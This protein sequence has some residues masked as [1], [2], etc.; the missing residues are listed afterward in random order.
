MSLSNESARS[1]RGSTADLATSGHDWRQGRFPNL[2]PNRIQEVLLVSS[3]YDSFILEEDGLLTEMVFTEYLDLGLTH[4]PN[5]TRVTNG[6]EALARLREE[7][8]DLVITMLRL[9]DMNVPKFGQAVRELRPGLPLVLLI[10]SEWELARVVHQQENLNVDGIY[11]WHGDTKLFIAIIKVIEDRL[12]AAHDAHT[13]DVGVII[14]VEDSVRFRSSLL[15]IVYSELVKQTRAV[16]TEGLNHMDKL[17]RM[18]ARPKVLVAETYEQGIEYYRRFRKQLFGVIADVSFPRAG[19]QNRRAGIDFIRQIKTNSPDIPALLQSSDLGNRELA[20]LVGAR[21]L[22]KRSATLLEDLRRFMLDHFGFGDF[23]FRLRDGREVAR[24]ANLQQMARVL[25]DVPTESVEY[26]AVRN[27]FSNWLR[28]RTEFALARRLRPRQVSEFEN[29]EDLRRYL[30]RGISEAIG[31]NRRGLV[32]DFSRQRF[33]PESGFARIG[34]GSMGGKARG[35]AFV[36][37]LLARSELEDEFPDIRVQVPPTVVI[38]TDIFDEFLDSNGIRHDV[39]CSN[40]DDWIRR[41]F[42]AGRLPDQVFEDLRVFIDLVRTP[43]AVRSSSLLEDSQYYPFAGV[44]TTFMLPNNASDDTVRLRQLRDAI[45]LVLASTFLTTARRYL[46]ATPHRIEEEKMAVILQPIIGAQRGD[47]FYPDFSG[48]ARSYNYYP[49]GQMKPEDGVATVALGLGKTVVDGGQALRF[50]PAHPQILPQLAENEVFIDQ[51]QRAFYAVDLGGP[52]CNPCA[53]HDGCLKCLDL[54]DAENHGTLHLL[55]SV[56]SPDDAA[57]Y[58]GIHRPGVRVV[59]FAH[60]LKSEA[61]PLA[62]LLRSLLHI[63]RTGMNSPVEIEFAADLA[64]DPKRFAVLQIRPCGTCVDQESVDL[65][66]LARD[67]LLCYSAHALGNGN[68]LGVRDIVYVRPDHFDPAHTVAMAEQIGQ[69]NERLMEDNCPYVLIGPGRWGSS[70]NRLGI[71]VN[72][73]QISAARVIIETM[74]EDFIVEPSQGSHFFQNLTSFG[75]SYL[76]IN[77]FTED[78]FIDWDWLEQQPRAAETEF[79]RHVRLSHPCEVRVSGE[80]SH[81]AIL[82]RGTHAALPE[83]S[84]CPR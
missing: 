15:P 82:K 41:A 2:M 12:N 13:G 56:W 83:D 37:A 64:S 45:K 78:G 74:L 39:L 77:P 16:M 26:H 28:A 3:P 62:P 73:S 52:P 23:V 76:T 1:T 9:G 44:Y 22:H 65:S 48:V 68:T 5:I 33:D 27:H 59:T 4:A 72:W 25:R 47:T 81:G 8:F 70:H 40:D 79:V 20:E 84:T 34:G 42:M 75:I 29:L 61:F 24:A 63:G 31:H 11:V 55:G 58:D 66:D 49:F 7:R 18:R 14:L 69:C 30:S 50:C 32:E 53:D 36:N 35:L 21:F 71:P 57:F 38:G 80:V 60:I 6:E 17:L 19:E 51:S 10:S 43:V 54:D 67:E 46:E